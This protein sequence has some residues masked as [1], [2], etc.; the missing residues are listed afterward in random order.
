MRK[1]WTGTPW[2][3]AYLRGSVDTSISGSLV[4]WEMLIGRKIY[5]WHIANVSR[6]PTTR[7]DILKFM[8]RKSDCFIVCEMRSNR[9][10]LRTKFIYIYD[11]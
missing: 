8:I 9:L 4:L 7:R 1:H 3:S 10:L 2:K 5:G 11:L 6:V